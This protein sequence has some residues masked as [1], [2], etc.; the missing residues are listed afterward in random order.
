MMGNLKEQKVLEMPSLA[1]AYLGDSVYELLV[2]QY[3][4]SKGQWKVKALH[5]EAVKFVKAGS[6]ATVL[7]AL[8]TRLSEEELGVVKRGRNAKSNPPKNADIIDYKYSTALE[9]LF[10]FLYLTGKETRI[11]EIFNFVLEVLETEGK[12]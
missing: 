6:Q 7:H 11:K 4:L 3:L 1:L 9:A 2:R 10:G 8:E 5:K 12:N